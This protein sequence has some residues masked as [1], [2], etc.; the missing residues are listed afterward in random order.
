M[1]WALPWVDEHSGLENLQRVL[2]MCEMRFVQAEGLSSLFETSWVFNHIAHRCSHESSARYSIFWIFR[3]CSCEWHI[4]GP[5]D[6]FTSFP[7]HQSY[8]TSVYSQIMRTSSSH[9]LWTYLF[10]RSFL[11]EPSFVPP[12]VLLTGLSSCPPPLPSK[13]FTYLG[14]CH[15]LN[16]GPWSVESYLNSTG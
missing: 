14:G 15:R 1:G 12:A 13:P 7:Q 8:Q 9:R 4:G 10:L 3:I 5:S 6:E 11:P 2:G 16:W